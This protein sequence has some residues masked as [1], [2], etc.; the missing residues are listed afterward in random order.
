MF[1][2]NFELLSIIKRSIILNF[3][4]VPTSYF[5]LQIYPAT[6]TMTVSWMSVTVS[7]ISLADWLIFVSRFNV[8]TPITDWLKLILTWYSGRSSIS[9]GKMKLAWGRPSPVQAG[10]GDVLLW[11]SYLTHDGSI[12]VNDSPCLALFACWPHR[13]QRQVAELRYEVPEDLWK[14]WAI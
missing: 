1:N 4:P 12:N 10:A 14:Y 7:T 3:P 9:E 8:C 6:F 5:G 11:H 2:H 13:H